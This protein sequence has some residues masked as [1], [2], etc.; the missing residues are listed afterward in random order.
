MEITDYPIGQ[1]ID[2][3]GDLYE[4]GAMAGNL[5][6]LVQ[7]HFLEKYPDSGLAHE[8]GQRVEAALLF[9]RIHFQE[10]NEGGALVKGEQGS[11]ISIALNTALYRIFMSLPREWLGR[12][13]AIGLVLNA[14][15]EQEDKNR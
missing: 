7:A 14:V 6:E 1:W 11:L 5:P 15:R 2:D 4:S 13:I 10:L 9:V 3:F 12:E 8:Q